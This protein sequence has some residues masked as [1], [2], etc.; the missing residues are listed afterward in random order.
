MTSKRHLFS[1]YDLTVDGPEC[2]AEYSWGKMEFS[3][4]P[5]VRMVKGPVPLALAG[6]VT[7]MIPNPGAEDM[8]LTITPS[9]AI[10]RINGQ[11]SFYIKNGNTI[12]Y[13]PSQTDTFSIARTL[14]LN[15]MSV[16]LSQRGDFICHG[17]ACVINGEGWIIT[18]ESGAGKSTLSEYS[19]RRGQAL[20]YRY[21]QN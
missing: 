7:K 3:E 8:E 16:L 11:G 18:G 6:G 20:L 9:E 1:L 5:D 17:N 19:L 14:S 21:L 12:C 10:I 4:N 13:S 2:L 15:C